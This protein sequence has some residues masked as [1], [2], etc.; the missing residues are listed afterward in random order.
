M[1]REHQGRGGGGWAEKAQGENR[2]TYDLRTWLGEGGR[3][4]VDGKLLCPKERFLQKPAVHWEARLFPV[5]PPSDASLL[6][7]GW[8]RVSLQR[9]SSLSSDT[10]SGAHLSAL[11]SSLSLALSSGKLFELIKLQRLENSIA[12]LS[13]VYIL[14]EFVFSW[15]FLMAE[16][17]KPAVVSEAPSL[18]W[19]PDHGCAGQP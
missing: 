6:S 19:S 7:G 15:I 3:S 1:C 13:P 11:S 17:H 9:G 10:W 18:V 12:M 5:T 4:S 16:S 8:S 14:Q 2:A